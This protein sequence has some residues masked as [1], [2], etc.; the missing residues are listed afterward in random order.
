MLRTM[1][2][3]IPWILLFEAVMA[4]R[5]RWVDLPPPDR[6]RLAELARRSRGNPLNLTRA[7][8]ADF[9]RIATGLDLFGVARDLAPMGRAFRRRH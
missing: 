5:R 4:M 8:R 1:R 7:E 3:K 2:R 9:R 6:A